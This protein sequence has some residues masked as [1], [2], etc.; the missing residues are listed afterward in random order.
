[1]KKSIKTP[2]K[3]NDL[4]D[5]DAPKV[6]GEFITDDNDWRGQTIEVKSDTTLESDKGTG[7]A[8]VIRSF[9]FKANPQTFKDYQ[10]A[11]GRLPYAQEIFESHA[12]GMKA[13]LWQDGLV[14]SEDIAPRLILSRK[15]YWYR[16]VVGAIPQAGQVILQTPKTLSEYVPKPQAEPSVA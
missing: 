3:I 10:K 5:K 9:E 2:K 13:M 8:V 16:I 4:N 12:K 6:G 15:G 11:H 1:M 14:P 7:N